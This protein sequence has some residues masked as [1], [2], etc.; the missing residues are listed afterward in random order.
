MYSDVDEFLQAHAKVLALKEM[1]VADSYSIDVN[2][3]PARVS[4]ASQ[5]SE[6]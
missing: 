3:D 5:K 6:E 4:S 2:K 1:N